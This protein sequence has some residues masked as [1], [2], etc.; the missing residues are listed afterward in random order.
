MRKEESDGGR[1]G[2]DD[3]T[4]VCEGIVVNIVVG[5]GVDEGVRITVAGSVCAIGDGGDCVEIFELD[6]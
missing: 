4:A 1:V 3:G 5:D 2:L 6:A